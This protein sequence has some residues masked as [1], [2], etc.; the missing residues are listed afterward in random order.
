M[1]GR[2]A[3]FDYL[4]ELS[5]LPLYEEVETTY[6]ENKQIKEK[7]YVEYKGFEVGIRKE[8]RKGAKEVFVAWLYP[9][10]K[11]KEMEGFEFPVTHKFDRM[12]YKVYRVAKD[13]SIPIRKTNLSYKYDEGN[14]WY[15]ERDVFEVNGRKF[16]NY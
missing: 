7:L 9:S 16:A 4:S 14:G 3:L 12:Y 15:S 6:E 2:Q 13:F 5:G 8:F 1:E 11:T 10:D